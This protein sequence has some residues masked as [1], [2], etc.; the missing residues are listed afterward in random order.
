MA[1]RA[2]KLGWRGES[3][4]RAFLERKGMVFIAQHVRTRSG[5]IDLVMRDGK[6]VV[7]A[8]V[9]TRRSARYGTPEEALTAVKLERMF[10]AAEAYIQRTG[11]DVPYRF[12]LVVVNVSGKKT[13]IRHLPGILP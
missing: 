11:E 10:A 7:F 2:T 13:A 1:T 3:L 5:E 12:D 4:A 8:E 6:T 9:K